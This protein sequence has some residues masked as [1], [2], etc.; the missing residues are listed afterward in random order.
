MGLLRARQCPLPALVPSTVG[1]RDADVAQPAPGRGSAAAA[2][3]AMVMALIGKP[4]AQHLGTGSSLH[5]TAAFFGC[6]AS[7]PAWK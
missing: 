5:F 6:W 2:A 4:G 3:P 1:A 7:A